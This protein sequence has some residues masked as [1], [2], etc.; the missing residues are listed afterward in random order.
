MIFRT[1]RFGGR[2]QIRFL[3]SMIHILPYTQL[4]KQHII[5]TEEIRSPASRPFRDCPVELLQLTW[6][7]KMRLA[8]HSHNTF[9]KNTMRKCITITWPDGIWVTYI[10]DYHSIFFPE[11]NSKGKSKGRFK[12]RTHRFPL[13]SDQILPAPPEFVRP[14]QNNP[15]SGTKNVPC[16]WQSINF[17]CRNSKNLKTFKKVAKWCVSFLPL[18]FFSFL[19]PLSRN[20]S[21]ISNINS[22]R[23]VST[24]GAVPV[25]VAWLEVL[26]GGPGPKGKSSEPTPVI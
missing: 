15:S 14:Q 10:I 18:V 20:W 21:N 25:N 2:I 12:I 1:S 9:A 6:Q 26:P 17:H 8:K 5:Y 13:K 19:I 24:P 23:I 7:K 4:T 3:E 16:T 22:S 11:T